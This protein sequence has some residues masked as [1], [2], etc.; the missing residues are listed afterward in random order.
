MREGGKGRE[1]TEEGGRKEGKGRK[2]EVRA[3]GQWSVCERGAPPEVG[4]VGPAP[5]WALP[6]S[7]LRSRLRGASGKLFPCSKSWPAKAGKGQSR[8]PPGKRQ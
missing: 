4:R 8:F 1:G 7:R 3:A 5:T 2:E 6:G